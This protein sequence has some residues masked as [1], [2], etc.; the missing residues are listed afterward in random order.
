MSSRPRF[1]APVASPLGVLFAFGF[2]VVCATAVGFSSGVTW[3]G[4]IACHF[5][6]QYAAVLLPIAALAIY[7][8]YVRERVA[9]GAHVTPLRVMLSNVFAEVTH[10]WRERLTALAPTHPYS[11]VAARDDNFGI[12]LYSRHPLD[13]GRVVAF[14]G[15]PSIVPLPGVRVLDRR[16]GPFV[17]SDHYP[18]IVDLEVG[19]GEE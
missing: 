17:G 19:R 7:P 15:L 5:R 16:V 2:L 6:P 8:L 18:L 13:G 11:V 4:E 3:V 9:V 1:L 14:G 10:S 12:A